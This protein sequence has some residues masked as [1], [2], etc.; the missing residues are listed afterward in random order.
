MRICKAFPTGERMALICSNAE[1]KTVPSSKKVKQRA[2]IN[3]KPSLRILA[4]LASSRENNSRS[5]EIPQ[6]LKP[7]AKPVSTRKAQSFHPK[8]PTWD[9]GT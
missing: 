2:V 5:S 4:F 6:G 9:S 8:L 1:Y 7:F 3:V